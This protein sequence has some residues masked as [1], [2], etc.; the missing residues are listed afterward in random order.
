MSLKCSVCQSEEVWQ[1]HGR[2]FLEEKM[3]ALIRVWPCRCG[4]CRNRFY[5]FN[6]QNGAESPRLV[7]RRRR[8]TSKN[9]FSQ[10]LEPPDEKEFKELIARIQEDEKKKIGPTAKPN[11]RQ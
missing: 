6:L 1:T 3:M 10:F 5:R 9:S 2:G 7:E 8:K 11:K 4:S